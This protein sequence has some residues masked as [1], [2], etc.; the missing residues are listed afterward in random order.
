MSS[1]V[2][3]SYPYP[4]ILVQH[5]YFCF[6]LACGSCHVHLIGVITRVCAPNTSGKGKGHVVRVAVVGHSE[7]RWWCSD[8]PQSSPVSPACSLSSPSKTSSICPSSIVGSWLTVLRAAA[9][10]RNTA[11]FSRANVP[12]IR[13][14]RV[15][16]K[17]C[18]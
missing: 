17:L 3:S 8:L 15:T 16:A 18:A 11:R 2:L 6:Q 14:V 7:G 4:F 13:E 10:S 12:Q 1:Q 9:A 5:F